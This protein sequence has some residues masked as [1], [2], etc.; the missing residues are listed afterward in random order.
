M[1]NRT[2]A[3]AVLMLAWATGAAAQSWREAYDRQDYPTAAAQLQ[4][5]VF[6]HPQGASRYPDPQAIQALA[7]LYGEGRGVAKNPLTACALSNLGSGAAVYR[8]GERDPRTIAIQRQ[9]EAYCVPLTA[10]ERRHIVESDGCF[11]QG[12]APTVLLASEHRRIEVS[13]SRLT[14]V[15]RGR[16]REF[17]LRPLLRCAQQVPIVRYVRVPAPRGSKIGAR[18]FVE[19]YSWHSTTTNGQRMRS[20]EWSAVELT[21]QS[22]VLRARTVVERGAGSTWPMRPVPDAV[23]SGAKFSMHKSGDVRWQLTSDLHGVI[24]RP[25]VMQTA[26]A[27]GR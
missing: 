22:P 13:P 3:V 10:Q 12:P 4:S 8:H 17:G 6:E 16:P 21:P 2:P 1:L 14:V 27:N 19:I 7:Q 26:S 9:V 24:G 18:E 15:N 20:L 23:A 11:Q 5:I 25:G